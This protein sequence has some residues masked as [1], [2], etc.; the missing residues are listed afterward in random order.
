[1]KG[2]SKAGIILV[3][4]FVSSIV[5]LC[6]FMANLYLPNRVLYYYILRYS[7]LYEYSLYVDIPIRLLYIL[8]CCTP[9]IF[10]LRKLLGLRKVEKPNPR[11]LASILR[12]YFILTLIVAIIVFSLE[13]SLAVALFYPVERD[14]GLFIDS[15]LSMCSNN[16]SCGVKRVT[17][18]IDSRLGWSYNNPMSALEIDNML[19]LID[20]WF[21]GMLGFTQA[22]VILWQ[23]WGSCGEHAIV[24][25]HLLNKLG[26]TVRVAHFNDIDHTWAEVY[27][28]GSWYI[29]DPWYI[30]GVYENQYQ[31]N[32]YLV[33]IEVLASLKNFSGNHK[34]LCRY[35]ND[36]VETDCTNEHGY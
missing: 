9:L 26:Y 13:A 24:T 8:L 12:R 15:T 18:Y 31:G 22:H 17:Q 33:P 30:G 5:L 23:G 29:V 25:A 20:Y 34:V 7:D 19:S 2:I 4:G 21:L 28:N 11:L 6:V 14:I 1:M 10:L 36:S 27:V 35:L 3:S 16:V 32:K